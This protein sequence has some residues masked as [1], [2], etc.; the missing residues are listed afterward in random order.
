M[1]LLGEQIGSSSNK[2]NLGRHFKVINLVVSL[3]AVMLKKANLVSESSILLPGIGTHK[4]QIGYSMNF[5]LPLT[6]RRTRSA[7]SHQGRYNFTRPDSQ[8]K[9]S[10]EG[11]LVEKNAAFPIPYPSVTSTDLFLYYFFL[12]LFMTDYN[13]FGNVFLV[14]VRSRYS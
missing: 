7:P 10:W 11:T 9:W 12:F 3:F 8:R 6:E 14:V 4:H 2:K 5:K 1:T 13:I